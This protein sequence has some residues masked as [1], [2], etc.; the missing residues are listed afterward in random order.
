MKKGN[1]MN[2]LSII[3]PVFNVNKYIRRCVDSLT[4][5]NGF[6]DIEVV[7]VDDGSTDGSGAIC[8]EYADEY[9]NIKVIHKSNGGLS[10]A[11]NVA[12]PIIKGKYVAFLD[13]DDF[14]TQ[15]YIIDMKST[16][17]KYMPDMVCYSYTFENKPGEYEVRG[18]KK[19]S[20]KGPKD[21]IDDLLRNRIGNQICFNI[22]AKMLFENVE[23][24]L[25]R[26]YEDIATLYKLIINTAKV[27]MID[28]TYYVYNITNNQSITKLSTYKNINDMYLSLN[29]QYK[30]LTEYF[31]CL[32]K[33]K[34][35]L[36]YYMIDKLIYVYLKL[37]REVS[38]TDESVELTKRVEQFIIENDDWRILKYR[39]YNW[40]KYIYFRITHILR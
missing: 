7:L 36:N 29:E 11:R 31:K 37:T 10:D 6:D 12:L 17:Q 9:I 24:P 2:F 19:V 34:K 15:D 30:G 33:D 39:C 13:S 22:Y 28:Y 16:I 23:F 4:T 14:L 38:K 5:Q 18:N 27:V 40:K 3:I 1:K 26:A 20:I 8:D 25:G 21:T 35:N 32:G